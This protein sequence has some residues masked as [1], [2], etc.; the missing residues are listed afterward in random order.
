MN[1]G[2]AIESSFGVPHL[3]MEPGMMLTE[4]ITL[5]NTQRQIFRTRKK[6]LVVVTPLY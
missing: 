2:R 4:Q 5:S 1:S 3:V 6:S